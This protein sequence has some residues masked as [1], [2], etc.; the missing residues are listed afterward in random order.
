MSYFRDE[1]DINEF[2]AWMRTQMPELKSADLELSPPSP[3]LLELAWQSAQAQHLRNPAAS[4]DTR[5]CYS[6][7]LMPLAAAD[8]SLRDGAVRIDS[9]GGEWSLTRE[10]LPDDPDW[11]I[12]K[13]KCREELIHKFQ[14]RQVQVGIGE[15]MYDLGKVSR[16]GVAETEVPSGLDLS[17]SIEVS[18]VKRENDSHEQE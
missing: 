6:E 17:Q 9:I 16:R 7:W 12:L 11:Q 8:G 14:Y 13:F 10:T 15:Q 4:A 1:Q 2:F 18:I 3:E 5:D